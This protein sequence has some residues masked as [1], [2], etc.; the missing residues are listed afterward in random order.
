MMGDF[1][2]RQILPHLKEYNVPFVIEG[3]EVEA[4]H[5]VLKNNIE[6]VQNILKEAV[7]QS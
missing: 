4:T 5:Q 7:L 2:F 6:Y 3:L 1:D